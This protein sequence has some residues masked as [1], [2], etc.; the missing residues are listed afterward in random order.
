MIDYTKAPY[1][2]KD[3]NPT[4]MNPNYFAWKPARIWRNRTAS[5][6]RRRRCRV[7]VEPYQ[8]P[9]NC[10]NEPPG[11]NAT[12]TRPN[13]AQCRSWQLEP[14]AAVRPARPPIR[15]GC[16]KQLVADLKPVVQAAA[17]CGSQVSA[18]RAKCEFASDANSSK[19]CIATMT[20]RKCGGEFIRIAT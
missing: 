14:D 20:H 17:S 9:P 1:A 16:E 7:T 15:R 19:C 10:P 2:D 6:V 3:G 4:L 18:V 8:R 11:T 13:P 12:P 5:M